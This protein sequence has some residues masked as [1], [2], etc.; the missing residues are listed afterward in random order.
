MSTIPS[1]NEINE[2]VWQACDTFRGAIDPAQYK[3]YILTMLFIKYM[4][5]L[6]KDKYEEYK[7]RYTGDEQRIQ[8]AMDRER[9]RVPAKADF[10]YLYSQREQ[11]DIGSIINKALEKIEEANK[12]KLENVFR[13][14]DFNSEAA[15]GQAKDRN[16]RLKNLLT[17]FNNPKLDLRPS[18][19]HS[20]DVIGDVYEYLIARFAAGAGKK[21]GEFYTPAEVS[22][23]LAKLVNP[24]SG[25]RICD[26]A[27]GSGS[28]L[29]KVAKEVDDKNYALYGQESNGSTWSLCKMN[30]FLHEM[31]SSQIEWCDTINSPRLIE[32]DEL[33][34]FNIVVANPP[35]SL[36]KWGYEHAGNDKFNRFWRG[37]PPKSKGDYA[38]ISHMIETALKDEGRVGV[39]VP[40]GVLFRGGSEGII[41]TKLVDENLLEAVIGLPEKLFYGVS[42]SA[43]ILIFNKARKARDKA[44]SERDKHILFIDASRE[45]EAGKKQ[46]KLREQ[47]ISKIVNTYQQFE[48]IDKYSHLASLEEIKGNDYN[49]NIPRYVDTYEAAPEIDI[50]AVQKEIKALEAEL[51]QVKLE[52]EAYLKELGLGEDAE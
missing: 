19:L 8:R 39:I 45:Y 47:D 43:S 6:W 38:F 51:V 4:S 40:H 52:M 10:D 33:M 49:L 1:K 18:V 12:L 31:D 35:F 5:D 14:I 28:L 21:A 9:F 15:L 50:K 26:P 44:V 29:I 17:D 30:M 23:L 37:I 2:I 24:K 13:N 27:C 16:R 22:E 11:A 20:R 34:R 48:Q 46:F 7:E 41:R 25:D 32:D 3:D 36:D 42:I